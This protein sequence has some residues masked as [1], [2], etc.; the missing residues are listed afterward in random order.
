MVLDTLS[1]LS[2]CWD[3]AVVQNEDEVTRAPKIRKEVCV[4]VVVEAG[5]AWWM[6]RCNLLSGFILSFVCCPCRMARSRGPLLAD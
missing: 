5:E 2:E 4:V 6:V 1:R 3:H